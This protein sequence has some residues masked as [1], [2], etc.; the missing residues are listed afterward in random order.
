MMSTN[1]LF[2]KVPEVNRQKVE[3]SLMV[4]VMGSNLAYLLNFFLLYKSLDFSMK[5]NDSLGSD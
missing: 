1:F 2:S 3:F 4:K 5:L